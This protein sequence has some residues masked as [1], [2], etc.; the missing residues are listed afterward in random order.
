MKIRN[1]FV[2]NSS[3]SSFIAF[4]PVAIYKNTVSSLPQE[5]RDIMD[6]LQ[7]AVYQLHN[8][9]AVQ[10]F[11]CLEIQDMDGELCINGEYMDSDVLEDIFGDNCLDE[12]DM[13]DLQ[14]EIQAAATALRY[15]LPEKAMLAYSSYF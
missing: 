8:F 14:N 6:K 1:G 13:Y 11:V 3:S 15:A 5:Y 9:G 2:S 12:D 4:V 10:D 7:P